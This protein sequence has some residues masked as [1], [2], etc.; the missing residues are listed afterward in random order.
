MPSLQWVIK[1][2]FVGNGFIR[3]AI[4]M[5]DIKQSDSRGR[6]SL[7]NSIDLSRDGRPRPSVYRF[8]NG[9]SKPRLYIFR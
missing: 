8:P 7:Q 4:Y 2:D 5:L 3:S 1:F 6:L 9:G